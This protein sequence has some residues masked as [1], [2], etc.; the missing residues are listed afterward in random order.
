MDTRKGDPH[1]LVAFDDLHER[2]IAMRAAKY[3]SG[4][5]KDTDGAG[6]MVISRLGCALRFVRSCYKPLIKSSAG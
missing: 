5:A 1:A 4:A 3:D 6:L 2:V